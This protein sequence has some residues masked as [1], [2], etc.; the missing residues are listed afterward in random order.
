M[1]GVQ[2]QLSHGEERTLDRKLILEPTKGNAQFSP[3]D[4]DGNGALV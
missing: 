1:R 2:T 3:L 4:K